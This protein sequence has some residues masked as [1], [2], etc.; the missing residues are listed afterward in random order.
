MT[1]LVHA[2]GLGRSVMDS[3]AAFGAAVSLAMSAPKAKHLAVYEL[4]Q[5]IL[6]PQTAQSH[7]LV[8]KQVSGSWSPIAWLAYANL[9]AEYERTY[10]RN[11]NQPLPTSAWRSGDR[12]W[13]LNLIAAAGYA[14]ELRP[15]LKNLFASRTA[16]SL[17]PHSYSRGQKVVVWRGSGCTQSDAKQFWRQR[18]IL[19]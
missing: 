15:V 1:F 6:Q 16:R 8:A 13:A 18:P 2:P 3:A 7:V 5:I 19:A 10:M 12:L 9:S 11:P 14:S 17:S 4:E